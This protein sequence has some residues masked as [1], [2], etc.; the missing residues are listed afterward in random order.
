[1]YIGD[2]LIECGTEILS[3]CWQLCV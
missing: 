3:S 2:Y 1:V